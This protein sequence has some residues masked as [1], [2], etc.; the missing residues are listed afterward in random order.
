MSGDDELKKRLENYLGFSSRETWAAAH[1]ICNDEDN[2]RAACVIVDT[3]P[4]EG[5]VDAVA[6]LVRMVYAKDIVV[7]GDVGDLS[8][9]NYAQLVQVIALAR[10]GLSD[11][12]QE[13][14]KDSE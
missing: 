6:A 10:K 11:L 8:R 1:W 4:E 5:Q 9:I 3:S 14:D 2:L 13:E 7:A 12:A